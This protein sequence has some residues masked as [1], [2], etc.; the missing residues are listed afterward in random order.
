M[1]QTC[2]AF[3][4]SSKY[5]FSLKMCIFIFFNGANQPQFYVL[6]Y[7]IFLLL[8]FFYYLSVGILNLLVKNS[9]TL[10]K[11]NYTYFL[12]E[13]APIKKNKFY[14]SVEKVFDK[15]QFFKIKRLTFI[16]Y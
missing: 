7:N 11:K 6:I 15:K 14:H 1:P 13:T 10:N 4:I 12:M 2:F 16:K 3:L 9:L 8:K 5:H